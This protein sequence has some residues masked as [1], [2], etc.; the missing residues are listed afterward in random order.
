MFGERQL[1]WLKDSLQNS[2]ATF[3][4]IA[5]GGQML[6]PLVPFEGFAQ[7]PHERE[8]LLEFIVS[9]RIEGV[10]FL[11]GDRHMSEL[12]RLEREDCYPLYDFT[13]SPLSSGT[14][15]LKEGDLEFDNPAR[16]PGTLVGGKRN[17]GRI[18][19]EGKGEE[20]A[21]VVSC[22]DKSG[23]ALWTQTIKLRELRFK[24]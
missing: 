16:V 22:H 24:P 7:V 18:S 9:S 14:R 12:I 5:A 13:C 2:Q 17:Y 8:E 4:V 1:Q 10:F 3:K 21:L 20:R 19:V 23:T 11:S 6:N 15:N